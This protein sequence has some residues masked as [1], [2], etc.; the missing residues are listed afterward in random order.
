MARSN[1][2]TA[3]LKR[4]AETQ[5]LEMIAF[6][7]NGICREKKFYSTPSYISILVAPN[8]KCDTRNAMV[9]GHYSD[10]PLV[11]SFRSRELVVYRG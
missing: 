2:T 8:G 1:S 3:M 9:A 11:N 5:S 7:H 6:L 4:F 10:I